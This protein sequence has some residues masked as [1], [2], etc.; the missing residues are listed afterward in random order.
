[1]IP[2]LAWRNLWRNPTRTLVLIGAIALGVW[3]G[4]FMTGFATGMIKS[5]ISNAI[6]QIV[7]HIQVH[8]PNFSEDQDVKFR[9]DQ[10][11]QHAAKIAEKEEV[12]AVVVRTLATGMISSAKGARGIRV[13][14]ISPAEESKVTGL[15]QKIVEGEYLAGKRKNEILI[16]RALAEKLKVK[17]RSKLVLNM[18][19]LE[20]E[21]TPAAFR[22]V[23]IFHTG[24]KPFDE[25]HV[26][27]QRKDLNR[28]LTLT[29]EGRID[30]TTLGH[31]IAL[32]LHDTK[33]IPAIQ[34]AMA[35]PDWKVE[36][37]KEISPDLELY[38]SQMGFVSTIY[39]SIIMLALTFGIINTMLMAVLERIRELGMLM[40]IGM[41]KLKVFL[42]IMLEAIFLGAVAAPIGL[43]LGSLTIYFLGQSG[44]DLSM[45]SDSLEMYGM[46]PVVYFDVPSK[47]Y[48]QIPVFV[49][50]TAILAALYPA[51]KAIKLK[52]V[53]AIRKI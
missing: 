16:S 9:L 42:M 3:A 22:V 52:P 21:I 17:I 14:G 38:E 48:W 30:P 34:S 15:D 53:E 39:L 27:V 43:A 10:P 11:D 29:S 44:L 31:E 4:L 49:A 19:D 36:N 32:L 26:F 24:N 25:G 50:C 13:K 1:M 41:N 46:S 2:I 20:G 40:G 5:Y 51:Y 7:S 8:H 6:D 45:Y 33:N 18:Q 23:G 35:Q 37:Y 12:K 47:V 28:L